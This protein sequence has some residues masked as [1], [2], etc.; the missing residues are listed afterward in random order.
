M[1]SS[2]LSSSS[3]GSSHP[4]DFWSALSALS[5]FPCRDPIFLPFLSS[6]PLNRLTF[7]LTAVRVRVEQER[8]VAILFSRTHTVSEEIYYLLQV[9]DQRVTSDWERRGKRN[10]EKR[11]ETKRMMLDEEMQCVGC[12][13]HS[14]R[15]GCLPLRSE[16]REKSKFIWI[17]IPWRR[18]RRRRHADYHAMTADCERVKV[19]ILKKKLAKGT[20]ERHYSHHD[21]W[22][23]AERDIDKTRREKWVQR[24]L[25]FIRL[26]VQLHL[27][28]FPR[29]ELRKQKGWRGR[30]NDGTWI[31]RM[32][33]KEIEF[34][35]LF[36]V[37]LWA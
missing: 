17:I 6:L 22:V 16:S 11:H 9:T 7:E 4:Q 31:S 2:H 15:R 1:K 21:S 36:K 27:H 35:C 26:S 37:Q 8:K 14:A 20:N 10:W 3:F 13:V 19:S 32:K 25:Y 33:E 24:T 5:A 29:E 30:S 34:Y 18:E 23:K 28:S 12:N